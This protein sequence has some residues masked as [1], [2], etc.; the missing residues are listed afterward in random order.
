MNTDRVAVTIAS[1]LVG[2]ALVLTGTAR[3]I[4][5]SVM[6]AA[7][8]AQRTPHLVSSGALIALGIAIGL[9]GALIYP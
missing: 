2:H 1:N 3:A 5:N 7:L 8:K 9:A 4:F 6:T